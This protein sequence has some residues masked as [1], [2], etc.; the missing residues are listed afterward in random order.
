MRNT[1]RTSSCGGIQQPCRDRNPSCSRNTTIG[2]RYRHNVGDGGDDSGLWAPARKPRH[3]RRRI[4][5]PTTSTAS[6]R[7]YSPWQNRSAGGGGNGTGLADEQRQENPNPSCYAHLATGP[8][9]LGKGSSSS[10]R[11]PSPSTKALALRQPAP[12]D[13]PTKAGGQPLLTAVK[14]HF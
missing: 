8:K 1:L 4:C 2:A 12:A 14:Y 3:L 7:R 9:V 13:E 5:L 11:K 6:E 10:S